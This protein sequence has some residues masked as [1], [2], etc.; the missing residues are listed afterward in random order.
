VRALLPITLLLLSACG[1]GGGSESSSGSSQTT[2]ADSG[3]TGPVSTTGGVSGPP[4]PSPPPQ[5]PPAGVAVNP[6]G[7][8]DMTDMVNGQAV[9]E[10]LLVGGGNYFAISTNDEFGCSDLTSGTYTVDHDVFTGSGVVFLTSTATTCVTPTAQN[11]YLPYTLM[12]YLTNGTELN[13]SFSVGGVPLPTLGAT[14]DPLYAEASSLTKLVGNWT[15]GA[16]TL[17]VNSDGTFLEQQ[18]S[19][20][21]ISGAFTIMDAAHNLYGVSYQIS[22]CTSS[23]AGIVFTGLGYLNDSNPTAVQFVEVLSGP[24][25]ANANAPILVTDT[26]TF[27]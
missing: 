6:S 11:G 19:G 26:I 1:F 22:N 12:G 21:V 9:S 27:Q 25:P 7:I 10:V 4:N 23:N 18:A 20:C 3:G 5:P 15:D 13:L 2:V 17:T 14:V 8:W 16:S 24:N